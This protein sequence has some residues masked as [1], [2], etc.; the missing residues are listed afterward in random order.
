MPRMDKM[1]AICC[2]LGST[3]SDLMDRHDPPA[4]S[5]APARPHRKGVKIPVLGHLAAGIP[6]WAEENIVD[7][8]E[9]SEEQARGGEYFALRVAGQSMEPTI[10]DG[11][12]LI[13]RKQE[14]VENGEVAVVLVNGDEATVKEI[15]ESPAGLTLIGHNAAVYKPTTYTPKEV[16]DLPVRIIGRVMQSRHDF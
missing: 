8:E 5:A 16:Q 3:R 9:I 2:V 1:D 7:W 13:V 6:I 4:G 11:D 10:H 12:T 14:Q 15:H